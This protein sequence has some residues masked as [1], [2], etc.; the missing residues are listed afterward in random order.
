MLS[1]LL[2]CHSDRLAWSCG[3]RD[4]FHASP[5]SGYQAT[6]KGPWALLLEWLDSR[7]M[8]PLTAGRVLSPKRLHPCNR[9]GT[10]VLMGAHEKRAGVRE[11]AGLE[12][13]KHSAKHQISQR[14][15]AE[16]ES[17]PGGGGEARSEQ[18]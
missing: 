1:E 6:S 18:P 10:N 17:A 14:G 5:K 12:S 16:T 7:R 8:E 2:R 11:G 4:P 9:L 3:K 15:T 13:L